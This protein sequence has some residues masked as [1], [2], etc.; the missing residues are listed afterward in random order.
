MRAHDRQRNTL[1]GAE[2]VVSTLE[3]LAR[4]VVVTLSSDALEVVGVV[5]ETSRDVL[6]RSLPRS[7]FSYGERGS[8]VTRLVLVRE[9]S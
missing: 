2:R 9:P 4:R 6:S 8:P 7:T 3:E 1:T 5:L